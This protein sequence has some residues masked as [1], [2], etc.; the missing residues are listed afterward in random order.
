M[1]VVKHKEK[2]DKGEEIWGYIG[3]VSQVSS[4][5]IDVDQYLLIYEHDYTSDMA[6][7]EGILDPCEYLNGVKLNENIAKINKVFT[8]ISNEVKENIGTVHCENLVFDHDLKFP[9]YA[10]LLYIEDSKEFDNILLL[11]D[12]DT[13]L[14][15]D[16]GQT[17]ERLV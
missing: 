6:K 15:N 14:L 4:K 2:N 13:Y 3:N 17:I 11:T 16:K 1:F 12:Q 10:I 8:V 7:V 9:I 5:S